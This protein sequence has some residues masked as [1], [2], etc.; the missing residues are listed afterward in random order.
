LGKR[1]TSIWMG[2]EAEVSAR[3]SAVPAEPVLRQSLAA[4]EPAP[5]RPSQIPAPLPAHVAS[6]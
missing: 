5:L 3:P 6:A 1:L 4:V 2:Q